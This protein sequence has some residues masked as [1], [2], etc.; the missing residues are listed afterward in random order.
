MPQQHISLASYYRLLRGNGNFRRL[1]FA[2]IVSEL[3]DWFYMV[4]LYAMLLEFTGRAESIGLAF[5]LQV[6]P[7]ALTGPF[8]GVIND[9]ISRRQVMI[10]TDIARAV[11]ITCVLF[12]RTPAMVWLVYP[13]LFLETVM[14]GLFEP[15][16]TA[17]IPNIVREDETLIANT[18][19]SS[20]WSMNMF[21]GSA[22][23]GAAAVWLG[24]DWIFGLD[25]ASFLVSAWLLSRMR[26]TEPHL[27]AR[28]PAR[29]R[30]LF[31][32]SEVVEG[33][34]YVRRDRRLTSAILVKGALGVTG[35]S[36]VIFP[37]FGKEIF[38]WRSAGITAAQGA[39]IGM[40][41]LM[42]ARGLGSLI[43]PLTAAPWAAQRLS[44]LRIGILLGFI[45]YGLGYLTL[46]WINDRWLAYAVVVLSHMGGAVIWVFSTTLLQ[47]LTDD[48]YRGRVFAAEL[49]GCTVMLA[50]TSWIAGFVIDHGVTVRTVTIWTGWFTLLAA[51]WWIWAGLKPS[52][53]VAAGDPAGAA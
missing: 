31:D 15:A 51:L 34:R 7:Q 22:L 8:A 36:W 47:L 50:L 25:A 12:V 30:D 18:L 32:H 14:W 17:V 39:L 40:S 3:G 41:L 19:A 2:E 46:G 1:W 48:R 13:L 53:Q 16:R 49:A 44:R 52:A 29:V 27:A 45:A 37:I 11:I 24:R 28:G 26:F 4:S 20:T 6:L 33:L 21:I 23:G 38:P 42:G 5:A 35:A 43:G 9:R 10:F